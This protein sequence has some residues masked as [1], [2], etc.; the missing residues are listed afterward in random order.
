MGEQDYSGPSLRQRGC[1]WLGCALIVLLLVGAGVGALAVN[2]ALE[3]LAERYL[4]QPHD[5]VR[6]YFVAYQ[7]G[8]TDRALGFLC[9]WVSAPLD[10]F[11]PLERRT[12]NLFVEDEFPYPRPGGQVAVNYRAEQH[13]PRAQALLEREEE[14]WRVCA[15]E[16]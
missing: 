3:P 7:R 16:R 15:F 2:N 14:G 6:E 4:W 1:G 8:D 11:A 10:P 5:V 12:G 13:G 9:R